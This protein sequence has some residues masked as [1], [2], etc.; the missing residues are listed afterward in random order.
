MRLGALQVGTVIVNDRP[1]R[2][3]WIA[4]IWVFNGLKRRGYGKAAIDVLKKMALTEGYGRLAGEVERGP[5]EQVGERRAFFN[6]CGFT[7]NEDRSMEMDLTA[8]AS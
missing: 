8:A 2:T 7:V 5:Q 4:D 6:A 3:L 1:D